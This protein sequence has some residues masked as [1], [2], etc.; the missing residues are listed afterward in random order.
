MR[1]VALD[2]G[3]EV[4]VAG[5]VIRRQHPGANA[6]FITLEDEFGHVPLVV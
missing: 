5:L 2:D 3:V 6:I 1:L 4:T